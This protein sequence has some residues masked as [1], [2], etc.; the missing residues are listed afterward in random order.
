M[1]VKKETRTSAFILE[2]LPSIVP[3]GCPVVEGKMWTIG[4]DCLFCGKVDYLL[5]GTRWGL[6]R[7]VIH[8]NIRIYVYTYTYIYTYI[9]IKDPANFSGLVRGSPTDQLDLLY[10]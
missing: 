8:N 2:Y 1:E 6:F 7:K 4:D 3:D 5:I 10:F 9:H